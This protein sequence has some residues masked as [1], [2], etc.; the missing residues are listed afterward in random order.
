MKRAVLLLLLVSVGLNMGLGF[1]LK[2]QRDE[3]ESAPPW[4][5]REPG[6]GRFEQTD[7]RPGRGRFDVERMGR[8][9]DMRARIEPELEVQRVE[10]LAARQALHEAL[11]REDVEE[12]EIMARVG[13]MI[14]AQGGIDSLV[15]SGLVRE[16]RQIPVGERDEILRMLDHFSDGFRGR[17]RGRPPVSP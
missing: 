2:R 9:R 13:D 4:T 14:A 10:L 11:S 12:A 3:M 1:A 8:M 7:R 5:F 15:V 17:G 16:L 6:S